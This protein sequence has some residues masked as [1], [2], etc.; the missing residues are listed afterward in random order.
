MSV[1]KLLN[2]LTVTQIRP[3]DCLLVYSVALAILEIIYMRNVFNIKL[4][5]MILAH[6]FSFDD[7]VKLQSSW[8]IPTM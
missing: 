7:L 8:Y 1:E 6:I 3:V 2:Q 5:L 4:T